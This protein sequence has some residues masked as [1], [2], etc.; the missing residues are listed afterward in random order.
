MCHA[1][2]SVGRGALPLPAAITVTFVVI[3]VTLVGQGLSLI[4]LL[5][6]LKLEE[7]GDGDRRETDVR[8]AA[9]EAGLARIAEM[10]R[11]QS[12]N[13]EERE[14]LAEVAASPAPASGRCWNSATMGSSQSVSTWVSLFRNSR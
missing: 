13:A 5:R 14:V 2:S 4:P 3:F 12:G 1:C 11:V 6:W 9:L 7:D 10:E 8:L